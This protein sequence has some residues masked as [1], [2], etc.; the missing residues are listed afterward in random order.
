MFYRSQY[1]TTHRQSL[2]LSLTHE[3][4]RSFV[5]STPRFEADDNFHL[6]L[7]FSSP[8]L[9]RLFSMREN[10]QPL[11]FVSDLI[12]KDD[13]KRELFFL[14]FPQPGHPPCPEETGH[15]SARRCGC[16]ITAMPRYL[17]SLLNAA[18]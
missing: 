7:P 6:N 17:W 9:D 13:E 1:Q 2:Q 5:L 18:S 15:P 16:A 3:D 12:P 10:P 8:S 11:A 4:R 14:L